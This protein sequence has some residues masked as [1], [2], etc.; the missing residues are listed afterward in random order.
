MLPSRLG[1]IHMSPWCKNQQLML[2]GAGLYLQ[3]SS[4]GR[5]QSTSAQSPPFP[6]DP[7]LSMLPTRLLAKNI[8]QDFSMFFLSHLNPQTILQSLWKLPKLP[9]SHSSSLFQDLGY[10]VSSLYVIVQKNVCCVLWIMVKLRKGTGLKSPGKTQVQQVR[11][12]QGSP[13]QLWSQLEQARSQ[14]KHR[15]SY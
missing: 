3:C 6:W 4:L 5:A 13:L 2:E 12:L 9:S 7:A 10:M 11:I 8:S 15:L 1:P 14:Q